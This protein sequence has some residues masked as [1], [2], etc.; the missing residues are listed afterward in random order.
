M[1][2]PR[3]LLVC[4]DPG[5]ANQT[6][7]CRALLSDSARNPAQRELAGRLR[8]AIGLPE[9]ARPDFAVAARDHAAARWASIGVRTTDVGDGGAAAAIAAAAP[10]VVVTGT[11]GADSDFE[12]RFWIAATT[13]RVP[14]YALSTHPANLAERF[15]LADG[16]PAWPTAILA[17]TPAAVR[18]LGASGIPAERLTV[19]GDP[20][21]TMLETAAPPDAGARARLREAWGAGPR[22][23]V[24]LFVSECVSEMARAAGRTAPFDE[25]ACLAGLLAAIAAGAIPGYGAVD[26]GTTIV[27]VRPHP[28][29]SPDKYAHQAARPDARVTVSRAGD[30]LDALGAADLIAGMESTMLYEATLL[31]YSVVSLFPEGAFSRWRSR[32]AVVGAQ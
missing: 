7:A 15:R 8:A 17:D 23:R 24:V 20:H 27:V 18:E 21:L 5:G 11:S 2:P 12:K 16:T 4:R 3:V 10:D 26:S 13:A 30:A 32:N 6:I 19:L 29:D 14:C 28:K 22:D 31:G 1:S 9:N 25:N